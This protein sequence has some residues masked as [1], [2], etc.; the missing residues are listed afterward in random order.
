MLLEQISFQ[1]QL[2]ISSAKILIIGAGGIGAPA[3]LYLAGMGVG[4][5]GIIDG[6]S[7]DESNLHRQIIHK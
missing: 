1:G 4:T 6:D 5:L 3:A 7:V 2:K